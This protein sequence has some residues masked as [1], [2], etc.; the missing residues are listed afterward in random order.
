MMEYLEVVSSQ[1]QRTLPV[2][3]R[4]A[5]PTGGYQQNLI[6][7]A[8]TTQIEEIDYCACSIA[9]EYI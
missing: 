5:I 4:G 1:S 3:L 2:R 8:T 7:A 6:S 9:H